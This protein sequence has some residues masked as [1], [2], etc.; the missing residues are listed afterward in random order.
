MLWLPDDDT[1]DELSRGEIESVIM[2]TK[3]NSHK[4][5]V[6]QRMWG[7]KARLNREQQHKGKSGIKGHQ[8]FN[9]RVS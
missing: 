8:K 2:T 9:S 3:Q 4:E 6:V 5:V 1:S 7:D